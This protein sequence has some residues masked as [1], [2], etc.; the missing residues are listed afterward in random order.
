MG[1]ERFNNR[2]VRTQLDERTEFFDFLKMVGIF[3]LIGLSILGVG[4]GIKNI[5]D[6]IEAPID[7]M[8]Q[9]VNRH[10]VKSDVN[11]RFSNCTKAFIGN[12][13]ILRCR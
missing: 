12:T 1:I 11:Y 10:N 3:G 2:S 4:Y 5:N 8:Q 13:V 9:Y 7:R 6:N